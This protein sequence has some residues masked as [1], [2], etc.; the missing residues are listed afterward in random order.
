MIAQP[1]IAPLGQ[2]EANPTNFFVFSLENISNWTLSKIA[3]MK[4]ID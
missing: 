2:Q 3:I 4:K 1:K